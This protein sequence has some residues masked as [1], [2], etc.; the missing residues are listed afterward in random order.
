MDRGPTK[1]GQRRCGRCG[2]EC[3]GPGEAPGYV[4][5]ESLYCENCYFDLMAPRTRKT[6]WQY[7]SSIKSDYIVDR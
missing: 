1:D 6:H 3:G 5:R 2:R 7:I 4:H